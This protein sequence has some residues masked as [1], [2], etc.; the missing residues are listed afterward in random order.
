MAKSGQVDKEASNRRSYWQEEI[1]KADK[2]WSNFNRD[3]SRVVDRYRLEKSDVTGDNWKDKYNILY[4]STETTKP[5]LYAQTPKVE[6]VKRH[7]DRENDTVTYATMLIEAVGQYALESIDFDDTIRNTIEDYLLPGLGQVWCRY[8]PT[9]ESKYDDKNEAIPNSESVTSE[10]VAVDYVH[11]RDFRTGVGR[12]WGELP[13]VSRRVFYTKKAATKRFGQEKANKLTYSYRPN[14]NDNDNSMKD[15][16]GGGY[17][18]IIWEIWDKENSKVIWYSEDYPDDLLEEIDDPL[19]LENFFPCPRPLRAIS[20][21]RTFVPK[22]FYSQYRQQADE[23]D[24]I[25]ERIR[26][27]TTALRVVGV[28]DSSNETLAQVLAGNTNKMVPVTNWAMFASQGGMAGSVQ[29]LPI[30]EVTQVLREL[31]AQREIVKN[32]IYEITGFSDIVRGVSKASETLGAQKIKSDWARGRLGDLQKEVQRFCRD[33]IR[34]MT[35]IMTEQFAKETLAMYSG[36]EPPPVT[37][38]EQA[39]AAQYTASMLVP[40]VPGAPPPQAPPPTMQAQAMQKFEE[41]VKLL[42]TEKQ[43]CALIGIETDSTLMA[44]E[45]AERED[46][47]TF[48]SSAGAFLQQA[49]PM[50]LQY[51]D[52]RGL[53]GAILMF[54]IRTFRS[55]RPL[56][57][58]FETFTKKLQSQPAEREGKADPQAEKDKLAAQMQET[59]MELQA[60]GAVAQQDDATKRYEIDKKAET[61]RMRLQQDHEYRMAQLNIGQRELVLKEREVAVKEAE[62]QVNAQVAENDAVLR[63]AEVQH[64]AELGEGQEER[65]DRQLEVAQENDGARLALEASKLEIGEGK[66]TA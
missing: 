19:K 30:T 56:E 27:L 38:E 3:G 8:V 32:E 16:T 44:D 47:M 10:S 29:W 20:N 51:P 65:A 52:M 31:F 39:A 41:V 62:L 6:A 4:S 26:H 21:T 18:A 33:T 37:P 24:N 5:S 54:T 14:D 45:A 1:T 63:Q 61:E 40:L 34:I 53:L 42:K 13:W 66:E 25:T 43:R 23:L 50:A 11:Y 60:D 59:Q 46:R 22:A 49:G 28:Y 35:E 55:S 48:L 64:K 36:F 15:T 17:Q 57:K 58:E 9:I 7:Q 12:V 2:R